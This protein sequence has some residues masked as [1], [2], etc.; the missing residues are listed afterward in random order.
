MSKFKIIP[1]ENSVKDGEYMKASQ[2]AAEYIMRSLGLKPTI[3]GQGRGREKNTES[4]S[5]TPK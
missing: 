4:E 1:V 5:N 2:E 3:I